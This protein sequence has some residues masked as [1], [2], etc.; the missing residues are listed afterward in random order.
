MADN[1]FKRVE[2]EKEEAYTPEEKAPPHPSDLVADFLNQEDFID[3]RSKVIE[4]FEPGK[5]EYIMKTCAILTDQNFGGSLELS[6][7][8]NVLSYIHS[9]LSIEEVWLLAEISEL[10]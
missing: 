1:F 3:L 2:E 4:S 9:P 8:M 5:Y 7:F 6:R 10:G